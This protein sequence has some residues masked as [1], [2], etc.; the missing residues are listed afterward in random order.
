M[1]KLR[2]TIIISFLLLG[3]STI[4]VFKPAELNVSPRIGLLT[5]ETIDLAI[6][7]GR[8]N[9]GY[10]REL[11]SQISNHIIK[12]YP[13]VKFNIIPDD[14]FYTNPNSNRVTIKIAIASYDAGFGSNVTI[15]T[16]GSFGGDFSYG[17][18][19]E[20]KWNGI[21]GFSINI[22]DY[23]NNNENRISKNI[24]KL[25]SLPNMWGYKT[26]QKALNDSYQQVMQELLFLID[27]SLMK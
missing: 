7:D 18:I 11:K 21:T 23:R 1:I 8:L 14:E 25:V 4:K 15:I 3:C 2:I 9:K 10:S 5:G 12:S 13:S 22:Y 19:P 24:G 6:F 20:G 17:I 16:F 27:N 26:A